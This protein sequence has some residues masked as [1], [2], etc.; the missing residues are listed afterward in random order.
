VSERIF[1]GHRE[2]GVSSFGIDL[3][4]TLGLRVIG[5]AA[6]WQRRNRLRVWAL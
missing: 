3:G 1:Q 4:S 2:R 6:P 5:P